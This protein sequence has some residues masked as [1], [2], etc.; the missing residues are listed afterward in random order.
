MPSSPN[1]KR[2]YKQ[3]RKA[4]LANRGL[5]IDRKRAKAQR[6][7][8]KSGKRSTGDGK[9]AGHKTP[10]RAGGSSSS[11]NIKAQDRKSNRSSGGK[12]GNRSGKARGGR[13]GNK[14]GKA[15]GGR[16]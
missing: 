11:S 5:E 2:D 7:A 6:E 13:I 15:K 4:H 8:K 16:K 14:E 10:L 3:E 9:D 12:A 1:Y